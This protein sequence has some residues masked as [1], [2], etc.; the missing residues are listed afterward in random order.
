MLYNSETK[1]YEKI[2]QL[3]LISH[4]TVLFWGNSRIGFE[5]M[6][7]IRGSMNNERA[8]FTTRFRLRGPAI[9][10]KIDLSLWRVGIQNQEAFRLSPDNGANCWFKTKTLYHGQITWGL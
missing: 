4:L 7:R 9:L 2:E 3:P 1:N 6:W 8:I 10:S 5:Y